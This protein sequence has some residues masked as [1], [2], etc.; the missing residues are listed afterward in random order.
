M[1]RPIAVWAAAVAVATTMGCV[2][3]GGPAQAATTVQAPVGQPASVTGVPDSEK[4]PN[5]TVRVIGK[6]PKLTGPMDVYSQK[7]GVPSKIG[8]GVAPDTVSSI[9]FNY[10]LTGVQNLTGRQFSSTQSVV[11]QDIEITYS[12]GGPGSPPA[13]HFRVELSAGGY[14]TVPVDGVARSY[15]WSGVPTKKTLTFQYYF[16]D[17]PRLGSY[18]FVDGS[19]RVRYS[20]Q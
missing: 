3:T 19:G 14:V 18:S 11:C 12:D 16:N 5:V 2:L 7:S 13:T 20:N 4:S 17:E 6:L 8:V 10:T 9:P 1:S 15:C